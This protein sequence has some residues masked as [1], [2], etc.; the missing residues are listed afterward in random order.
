MAMQIPGGRAAD[1]WGARTTGLVGDPHLVPSFA[2]GAADIDTALV[3]L[4]H[5]DGCLTAI[6][7]SR[8]AAAIAE[9]GSG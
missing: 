5:E 6:D 4:V 3:T 7:N 2:Q 9:I 8:R 1:R